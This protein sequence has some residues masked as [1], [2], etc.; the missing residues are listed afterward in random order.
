MIIPKGLVDMVIYADSISVFLVEMR[1]QFDDFFP[2]SLEATPAFLSRLGT[3]WSQNI[4][5][6]IFKFEI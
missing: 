4:F 1:K 3:Q 5:Q 2:F 6:V